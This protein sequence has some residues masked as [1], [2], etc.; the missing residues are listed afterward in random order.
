MPRR[1]CIARSWKCSDG[2]VAVPGGSRCEVN[3]GL[4]SNWAEYK[5]KHRQRASS[6]QS[7]AWRRLRDRVLREEPDCRR[8]GTLSSDVDHIVALADGGQ[9]LDRE[10]LQALCQLCHRNKRVRTIGGGGRRANERRLFQ[11]SEAPRVTNP[12]NCWRKPD[13]PAQTR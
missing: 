6:Y 8:C 10:N 12:L 4:K 3:G 11:G 13:S 2:G 7:E 1:A 9:F 5:A